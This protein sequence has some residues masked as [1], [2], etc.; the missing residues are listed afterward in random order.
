MQVVVGDPLYRPFARPPNS[1]AQ[2]AAGEEYVFYRG[3]LTRQAPDADAA[4]LKKQLLRLAEEKQS[5]RLLELLA[6]H[7]WNLGQ[8]GEAAE[9]F[10]HAAAIAKSAEDRAR[11]ERYRDEARQ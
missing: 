10:E 7:C 1:H 4:V 6:L 3:L 9:L 2:D 5:P 11:L 8:A